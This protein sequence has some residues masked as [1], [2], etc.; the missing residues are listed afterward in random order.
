M[1]GEL[2][3]SILKEELQESIQ[4]YD[5]EPSRTIF[6][7]D[8]DLKHTCKLVKTWLDDQDFRLIKWPAQSPD[9]NPI[10]HLW[11]HL[12]KKAWRVSSLP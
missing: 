12:K 9:L 10:E 6:Q 1:D 3:L 7:Q 8:N 4:F 2:Y 11:C 5:F